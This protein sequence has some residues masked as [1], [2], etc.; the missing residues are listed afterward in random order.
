[1]G[2]AAAKQGRPEKPCGG[3]VQSA[4]CLAAAVRRGACALAPIDE[5][6]LDDREICS[7]AAAVTLTIDDQIDQKFPAETLARV[8]LTTPSGDITSTTAMARGDAG[9]PMLWDELK[10]K[11]RQVCR[12]KMSAARED[13][14][15][16]AIDQLKS[17]DP[18]PF[19]RE[20]SADL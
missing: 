13:V 18:L 19:L 9:R 4:F 20:V 14:F 17:G 16:R 1:M 6:L 8:K 7:L 10:E 3:S 2:S 12:G 15:D 5:Q 11:F